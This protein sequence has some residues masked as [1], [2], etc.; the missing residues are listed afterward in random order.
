M[1]AEATVTSSIR[2]LAA[3]LVGQALLG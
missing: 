2:T 1:A 3:H